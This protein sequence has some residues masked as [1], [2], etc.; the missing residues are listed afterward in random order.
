MKSLREILVFGWTVGIFWLLSPHYGIAQ[1]LG[2]HQYTSEAIQ[3]GLRIYNRE[4][5]LCHGPRGDLVSGINLRLGQFRNAQSD[6]DLRAVVTDGAA[7]GQMPAFNLNAEEL[8]G[9]VAYMRA[10]CDP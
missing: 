1:E 3:V 10:G 7:E 8:S 4:C 9:V 5:A 6:D 2:D